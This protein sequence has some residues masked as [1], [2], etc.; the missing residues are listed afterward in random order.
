MFI[1]FVSRSSYIDQ[2]TFQITLHY[3]L[4]MKEE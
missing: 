4:K 3:L 1:F 2:F